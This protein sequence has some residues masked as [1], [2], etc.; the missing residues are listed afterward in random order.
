MHDDECRGCA[1]YRD[2]RGG[3]SRRRFLRW[4]AG[5]VAA[6]AL[7]GW[8]PRVAYA[9]DGGDSERDVL[10]QIFLRGGSDALTL[11]VPYLEPRYYALRPTIAIAP[12]DAPG[13][14]KVTD[15]DGR[16]GFPPAFAPLLE[17]W[18]AGDLAVVHA[19]G[20]DNP[21]R[22][23]FD[24]MRFV[25]TGVDGA[26]PDLTTGWL[27]RHLQMTAPTVPD[28]VL[29]AVGI[30]YGLQRTLGGAPRAMPMVD[31]AAFD[32]AGDPSSAPARRAAITAMY[33][34]VAEPLRSA[35]ANTFR[36]IDLLDQIDVGGYVPADGA[37]YPEDDL[38]QAL[39]STAALVKAQVGVEAVAIDVGGWDTHD[40]QGPVDGGMA[41]VMASLAGG[42]AAFHA[43][44]FSNGPGNVTMVVL[45]EFGR[46]VFEN[47][48]AGTDHGHGG[49]MMVLGDHVEGGRVHG[50][51]PG[52]GDGQL[53]ED[54]DLAI[55][56]DY[57]DV[58]SEVLGK[59]LGNADPGT[60]FGDPTYTPRPVGVIA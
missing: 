8:L 28:A 59:R 37:R 9:S 20:L 23:H 24:A 39:R 15:L 53:Y 18:Q 36:T 6:A 1:E 16:F 22:S 26:A 44:L 10:V 51:W 17:S 29:R 14:N 38:G 48:S 4:G 3:V 41:V 5:A 57:R 19:C 12:P 46:N 32:F 2:A 27:G 52:L 21:T 34:D 7:P 13:P 31:P 60:V 49:L 56:T 33:Q 35:T 43:D 50:T 25:E 54:Q 40:L 45:S 47:G 11:C 30:G 55:T 58:L 42:M